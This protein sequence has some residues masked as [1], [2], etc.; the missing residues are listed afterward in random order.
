MPCC[1]AIA[2]DLS[3]CSDMGWLDGG[4]QAIIGSVLAGF[5]LP[6]TLH[7]LP[8]DAD[9]VPTGAAAIDFSIKVQRENW[10]A[11][12]RSNELPANS[13]KFFIL[14]LNAPAVP[15]VD[16]EMTLSGVRYR[17]AAMP[18]N[19]PASVCWTIAAVRK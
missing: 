1:A 5:Y 8:V 6:A 10:T 13:T 12:D 16:D 9:G 14:Q 4:A 2:A 3:W 15:T 18:E 19:D 11:Q 7:K 17:I